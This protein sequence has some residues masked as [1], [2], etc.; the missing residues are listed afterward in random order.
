[1]GGFSEDI[2]N[3]YLTTYT[4]TFDLFKEIIARVERLKDV[5]SPPPFVSILNSLV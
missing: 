5:V 1:M 4:D 3:E 2:A